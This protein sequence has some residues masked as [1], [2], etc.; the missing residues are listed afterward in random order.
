MALKPGGQ[1]VLALGLSRFQIDILQRR[2]EQVASNGRQISR[3]ARRV[4]ALPNSEQINSL[5]YAPWHPRESRE[6]AQARIGAPMERTKEQAAANFLDFQ[7]TIPG[8]NISL[9]RWI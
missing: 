5:Q 7:R 4:F 3:F 6:N 8:S 2:A 9:F 1:A